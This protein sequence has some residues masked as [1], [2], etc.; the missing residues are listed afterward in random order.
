MRKIFFILL[1]LLAFGCN[2]NPSPKYN[3]IKAG[4][5][6]TPYE[7]IRIMGE[8]TIQNCEYF[9]VNVSGFYV[10]VHKGNCKN[11]IHRN[12]FDSTKYINQIEIDSMKID[13]LEKKLKILKNERY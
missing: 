11:P 8:T 12:F 10:P 9:I 7:Q 3:I 6:S 5:E 2:Q 1:I 4:S 13:F